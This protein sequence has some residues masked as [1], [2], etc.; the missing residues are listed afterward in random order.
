MGL[1]YHSS[2]SFRNIWGG[3]KIPAITAIINNAFGNNTL[4]TFIPNVLSNK[5]PA[6]ITDSATDNPA[7]TSNRSRRLIFIA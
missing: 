4:S 5:N 1:I 2:I 7:Y 6:P 3:R